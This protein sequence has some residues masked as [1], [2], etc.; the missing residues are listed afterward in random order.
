MSHAPVCRDF[1]SQCAFRPKRQLVP[2]G[3]S[4]DQ[5]LTA[6][7]IARGDV[8]TCTV[9]LFADNEKQ[10]KIAPA[11]TQQVF[12]GRDHSRDDALCVTSATTPDMIPVFAGGNKRRDRIH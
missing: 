8:C 1:I 5:E 4:I 10:P 12:S 7:R 3:L 2:G 11:R 9:S 6:T